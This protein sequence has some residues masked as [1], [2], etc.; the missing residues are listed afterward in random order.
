[1]RVYDLLHFVVLLWKG[2][3]VVRSDSEKKGIADQFGLSTDLP[4][5]S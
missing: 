5:I 2:S 1:M 3:G 4:F